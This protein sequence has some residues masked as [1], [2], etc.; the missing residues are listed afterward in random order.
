MKVKVSKQSVVAEFAFFR[1]PIRAN[2]PPVL[3][4]FRTSA[5]VSSLANGSDHASR[6]QD[7]LKMLSSSIDARHQAAQYLSFNTP[8]PLEYRMLFRLIAVLSAYSP[9]LRCLPTTFDLQA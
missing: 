4:L 2:Q 9:Y 3:P 6:S 1:V 8:N 5:L 7:H